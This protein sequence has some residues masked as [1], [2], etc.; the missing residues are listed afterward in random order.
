MGCNA[1][2]LT[3]QEQPVMPPR[4]GERFPDFTINTVNKGRFSLNDALSRGPV[5]VVFYRGNWCPFCTNYLRS[6]RQ[7]YPELVKRSASIIAIAP[8]SD[9]HAKHTVKEN[10]LTFPVASNPS[11]DVMLKCGVVYKPNSALRTLH[12]FKN[13][14]SHRD[15]DG[16]K[17]R[18]KAWLPKPA[19]FVLQ[20]GTGIVLSSDVD[21]A[22]MANRAGT[23]Q[24]IATLDKCFMGHD[25]DVSDMGNAS[26]LIIVN[27]PIAVSAAA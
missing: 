4:E 2:N 16:S 17:V 15:E 22:S 3:K 12:D 10:K 6:I 24:I 7:A 19:T 8:E 9:Q 21:E 26:P 5:V 20:A 13:I 18:G 1:S 14:H 11:F 25:N 23:K 27:K